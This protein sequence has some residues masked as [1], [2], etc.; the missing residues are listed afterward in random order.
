ME[1]SIMKCQ[2]CKTKEAKRNSIVCGDTCRNTML[3]IIG[4]SN[5]YTPT[6]GCDNCLGDLHQGCTIRCRMESKWADEFVSDLYAL[7][8]RISNTQ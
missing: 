7:V 3:E 5:K 4:L 1:E 8:C 6:N 2:V